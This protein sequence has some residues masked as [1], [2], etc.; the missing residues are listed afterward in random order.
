MKLAFYIYRLYG[1]LYCGFF[2]VDLYVNKIND[3]IT[4]LLCK[5]QVL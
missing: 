4:F 3:K 1:I 5:G 2:L